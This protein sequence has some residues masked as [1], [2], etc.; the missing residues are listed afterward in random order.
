[1]NPHPS[2]K[3]TLSFS[4]VES[5]SQMRKALRIHHVQQAKACGK[6][7]IFVSSEITQGIDAAGF[8]N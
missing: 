7:F 8:R 5:K 3:I 4:F 6:K 1:L 2:G